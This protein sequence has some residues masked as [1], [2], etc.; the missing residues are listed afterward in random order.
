[1]KEED[2][3]EINISSP[4]IAKTFK[5][6]KNRVENIQKIEAY[7]KFIDFTDTQEFNITQ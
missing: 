6:V 1:M 2:L 5:K 3:Q 4:V 7:G